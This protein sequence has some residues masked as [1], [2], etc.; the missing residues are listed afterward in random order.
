MLAQATK[1]A[2]TFHRLREQKSKRGHFDLFFCLKT[3][4]SFFKETFFVAATF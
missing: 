4:T 1:T 3:T 2:A